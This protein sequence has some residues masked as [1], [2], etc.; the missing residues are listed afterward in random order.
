MKASIKASSHARS[1][2]SCLFFLSHTRVIKLSLL[3]LPMS[4]G[5]ICTDPLLS[6]IQNLAPSLQVLGKS[7]N[8]LEI[9]TQI[10]EQLD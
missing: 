7:G 9:A 3:Y 1:F 6:P 8:N 10:G 5:F 2:G 4:V